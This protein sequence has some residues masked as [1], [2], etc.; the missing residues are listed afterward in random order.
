MLSQGSTFS[1]RVSAPRL[2]LFCILAV[3]PGVLVVAGA[4]AQGQK[5]VEEKDMKLIGYSELQGRSAYQPT[6]EKQ[7][8]RYIAYVGHHAG[9]APAADASGNI[10]F[11][12]GNGDFDTTLNASGF[13][14]PIP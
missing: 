3:C 7:G 10:Y 13:P 1:F 14:S 5:Q 4:T 12:V 11:M 8:D 6:I 9:T 2:R